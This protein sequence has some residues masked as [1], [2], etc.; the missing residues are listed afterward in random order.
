ML[1]ALIS[2]SAGYS[3][4]QRASNDDY[5]N[6]PEAQQAYSNQQSAGN[7][8]ANQGQQQ[9]DIANDDEESVT[10]IPTYFHR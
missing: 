3:T 9:R 1:A 8:Y 4:Q 7:D 2:V 10:S 6:Q 5:S